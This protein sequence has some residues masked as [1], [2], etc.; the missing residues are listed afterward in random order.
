MG[1]CGKCDNGDENP[2]SQVKALEIVGD[3]IA[4]KWGFYF[5]NPMETAVRKVTSGVQSKTGSQQ[6][7]SCCQLRK[8]VPTTTFIDK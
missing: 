2:T 7:W 6:W 3:G 1:N 8:N 4:W 5:K